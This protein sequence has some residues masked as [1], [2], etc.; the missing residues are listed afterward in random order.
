MAALTAEHDDRQQQKNKKDKGD[1]PESSKPKDRKRKSEGMVAATGR[2]RPARPPRPDDF[3]KVMEAPCPFHP[4]G[5]HAAKDCF[6]LKK[7]VEE[8]SRAPGKD[9]EQGKQQ[10]GS[11]YPDPTRELNMIFGGS[12]AYESKR[13]QKLTVREINA[14]TPATPTYLRWSETPITFDRSDHPDHVPHPGRYPLVLTPIVKNTKLGKVLID[15]G[16]SL[17]ILFV[18]TMDEMQIPRLELNQSGAPFHGIIPGTSSIPLG[19]LTLPVTFGT[20]ENFRTEN[21][22]FEVADFDMAYHAILG[23]PALA[24]FMAVPHYTYMLLKMPGPH[25]VITQRGDAKQ[26]FIVEQE[27]CEI[28]RSLQ[29]AS[30]LDGIRLVAETTQDEGDVPTK[31]PAKA[32]IKPD[33]DTLPIPLDPSDPTK[34]ALVG[35][36]LDPK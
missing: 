26:S 17:N 33:E 25:G 6:S 23:R 27:S 14:V 20:R 10:D 11:G 24:K 31:K 34:T 8:N 16:S 12:A 7:F 2:D 19:H 28:A 15:G 36:G 5:K 21:I 1:A 29:A 18:R 13:K 9:D 22:S 4:K 3:R 35:T 32:G 30:D